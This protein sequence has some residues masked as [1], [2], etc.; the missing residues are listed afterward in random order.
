MNFVMPRF[1]A[2]RPVHLWALLGAAMVLILAVADAV[3]RFW[4]G[5]AEPAPPMA[6]VLRPSAARSV[7]TQRIIQAHL[8]GQVDAPAQK[9]TVAPDTR[10][11]LKLVGVLASTDPEQA[12]AMIAAD[13]GKARSVA[14][15]RPIAGTDGTLHAIEETRVLIRRGGA[16]E[17]LKL[18]R[19]PREGSPS[20]AAA[21]VIPPSRPTMDQAASETPLFGAGVPAPAAAGASAN[22]GATDEPE[23]RDEEETEEPEQAEA[24]VPPRRAPARK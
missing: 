19:K 4:P 10:L 21:G 6:P 9:V 1:V 11:R 12:R 7:D 15:G 3:W 24:P 13:G 18:E 22:T 2:Q 20:A 5:R 14:V 16:I 8:F 17:Q 23:E